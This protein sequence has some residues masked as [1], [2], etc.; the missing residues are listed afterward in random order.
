MWV[1]GMNIM[2]VEQIAKSY[3]EKI[4]FKDAS[5]GMEDQDKIG[6]VG[7]NGTGKSTFCSDCRFGAGR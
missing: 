6:V 5:F 4:L 1:T 7:V 3:G 2:T